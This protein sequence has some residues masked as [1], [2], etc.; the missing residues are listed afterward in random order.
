MAKE[1]K[2]KKIISLEDFMSHLNKEYGKGTVI[3]ANEKETYNKVI[4]STSY[5]FN[6]ASGIGGIAKGKVTMIAGL[7]SAGKSTVLYDVM[8]NDHKKYNQP[9]LL[10]DKED[11][12]GQDYGGKLGINNDLVKIVNPRT[13]EDMYIILLQ[14][15]KLN[16]FGVIGI[17]SVTTFVPKAKLDEGSEKM[18][19]EATI[20]SRYMPQVIDALRGTETALIG[21][22]QLREKPGGYGDPYFEPGGNAWLFYSHVR[23]RITRSEIDKELFQNTMK[24]HFPKN[25]LAMPFKVGTITYSWLGGFD[26]ESE[27]ADL[28]IDAGIITVV[29]RTYTFPELPDFKVTSKAK[30]IEHL[31]NNPEYLQSVIKPKITEYL[32]KTFDTTSVE[33]NNIRLD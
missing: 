7:P 13:L 23:I 18:L 26:T 5:S 12:Y 1:E 6:N 28:A 11:A 22:F 10:I 19:Q 21:L 9:S 17:D 29:G 24:F 30:A 32:A 33:D 2:E 25:K 20:H 15:I 4:P 3:D 31:K 14:A 8:A 16:I 27:L